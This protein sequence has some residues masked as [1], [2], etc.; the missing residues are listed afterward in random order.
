MVGLVGFSY[1]PAWLNRDTAQ[2]DQPLASADP[3]S[4]SPAI[5][6]TVTVL[7]SV[8]EVIATD[9][10]A[11]LAI[12]ANLPVVVEVANLSVATAIQAESAQEIDTVV[13][14]PEILSL[15]STKQDIK[16]YITQAGDTLENIAQTNDISVQTIKWANNLTADTIDPGKELKI[17]PVD[18]VYYQV[19]TNDTLEGVAEKYKTNVG[20]VV[21]LNNLEVSGLVPGSMVILP[22]GEL[23]VNERPGYVAPVYRRPVYYGGFVA[24]GGGGR[25]N[26]QSWANNLSKSAGNTYYAGNCTWYAYER[27]LQLGRPM[28]TSAGSWGDAVAWVNKARS[29]GYA[30]NNSPAPGAIFQNYGGWGGYGHVGIVEAVNEDGSIVVTEM[31]YVGYNIISRSTIKAEFVANY[32]Y[33]H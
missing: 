33:I 9:L 29:L 13:A 8:D 22:D 31:N 26:V 17:L 1:F 28:D 30:V 6:E 10:A 14:K 15:G 11:N 5:T 2:E 16:L 19:Q 3:V 21:A 18:G 32:N 4:S 24:R 7:Q 25:I 23:P 27:R 20:R 12:S